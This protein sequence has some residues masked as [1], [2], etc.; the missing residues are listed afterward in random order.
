MRSRFEV[1]FQFL[2]AL[3]L[4]PARQFS[5]KEL[6]R[7]MA[8]FPLV[9]LTLGAGLLLVHWVVEGR[10]PGFL[11]G[12]VLVALLAGATGAFHL[13]GLADTLDGLAGG[14]TRERALEIMKDSRT[15]A[16]GAAGLCLALIAK[17]AAL[18]LLPAGIAGR[19]ILLTPAV[20]R[21]SV[22][23]LAYKSAY[24]RPQGGLGTPYTEHLDRRTLELALL[25]S[26]LPCLLLGWKGLAAFGLTLAYTHGLK[27]FFHRRLGG[28]T[29]DVLGFA[30]ETGEILFLVALHLLS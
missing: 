27:G 23:W 20:A 25:G 22:V 12:A 19:A 6:A 17:V 2:T 21:G 14:W 26:G 13:D 15:G 3:P 10:L 7:S 1:A 8:A 28:I 29:G 4:F 5:P 30:E 24:A 9:G 16:I 18:G 11:E